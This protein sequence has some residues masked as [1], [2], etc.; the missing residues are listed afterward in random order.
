MKRVEE[1]F[2]LR[3]GS[4]TVKLLKLDCHSIRGGKAVL[5]FPGVLEEYEIASIH[6]H[7]GE[8]KDVVEY[9][10]GKCLRCLKLEDSVRRCAV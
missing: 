7:K 8:F 3:D 2:I 6:T 10:L 9:E 4:S 5:R 1:Y